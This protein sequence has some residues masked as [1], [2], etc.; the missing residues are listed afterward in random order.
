MNDADEYNREELVDQERA[1]CATGSHDQVD[2]KA[3]DRALPLGA[4]RRRAIADKKRPPSAADV[5]PA[6]TQ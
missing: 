5:I 3:G 4:S 6:Q 1:I 2:G